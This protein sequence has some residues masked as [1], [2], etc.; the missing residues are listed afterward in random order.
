MATRFSTT[1]KQRV[2]V[3]DVCRMGKD[4][5]WQSTRKCIRTFYVSYIYINDLPDF[6]EMD[7]EIYLFPDDAKVI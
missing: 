7:S 2:K 6:Y 4:H 3:N 1:Q 5:K